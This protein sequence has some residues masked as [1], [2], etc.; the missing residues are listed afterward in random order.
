[1]HTGLLQGHALSRITVTCYDPCEKLNRF[2]FAA[3][4]MTP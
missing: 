1:M 3:D 4:F 2:L